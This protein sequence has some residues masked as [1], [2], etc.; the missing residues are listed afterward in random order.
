MTSLIIFQLPY[1]PVEDAFK[2]TTNIFYTKNGAHETTSYRW[3]VIQ[4]SHYLPVAAFAIDIMINRIRIPW[5]HIFFTI[6]LT[7]LY[8][9][10]TYLYQVAR[11][12]EAIYL[13]SLNWNC[14]KDWS[15]LQTNDEFKTINDTE[16][17]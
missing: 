13:H 8:L 15:Y 4:I 10:F 5:H 12:D 17:I 1:F 3:Y 2:Q 14:E 11:R 16:P 9:F 7:L 6:L